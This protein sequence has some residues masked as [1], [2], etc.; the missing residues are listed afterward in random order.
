MSALSTHRTNLVDALCPWCIDSGTAAQMFDA[1]F[2]DVEWG[3]PIGVPASVTDEI[4][5]RTPG[6]R[7]WQQEHWLYH[8]DDGCAFLGAVG[9]RE[10]EDYPD[11]LEALRRESQSDGWGIRKPATTSTPSRKAARQPHTFP[12][13][14]MQ[15]PS[16]LLRLRLK[17]RPRQGEN[18]RSGV[19]RAGSKPAFRDTPGAW[20][21][22]TLWGTSGP[23]AEATEL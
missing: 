8:C 6:F 11:A 19:R 1:E 23:T 7:A 14:G 13:P 16:G 18:V 15:G 2:T 4:A 9:R 12:L 3:V 21:G 10:L 5:H 17:W 22:C 20:A